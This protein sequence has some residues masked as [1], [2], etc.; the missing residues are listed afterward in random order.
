M[1]LSEADVH[2]KN[3]KKQEAT[4]IREWVADFPCEQSKFLSP[5][6]RRLPKTGRKESM[7]YN[8]NVIKS[9]WRR[10]HKPSRAT[11]HAICSQ[12]AV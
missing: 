4:K 11:L 7:R 9:A 8:I 1:L 10:L 3:G 2:E 12:N 6:W 5:V